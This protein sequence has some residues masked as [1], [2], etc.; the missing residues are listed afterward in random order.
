[1]TFD[2]ERNALLV[3]VDG[4]I[5]RYQFAGGTWGAPTSAAITDLQAFSLSANGT[6]I[7][8]LTKTGIT[9]VN[10][11]TLALGSTTAATG[12]SS[13]HT[14]KDLVITNENNGVVTTGAS[15]TT[16][17]PLFA[18]QS[19]KDT[20]ALSTS[21]AQLDNASVGISANGSTAIIV[22]GDPALTTAP[23]V[24]A[25]SASTEQLS[26]FLTSITLNQSTVPP[27]LNTG[28]TRVALNGLNVYDNAVL[29]G[30][31]PA[32]TAAL[33]FK[34]DGTRAYTYDTTAGAILT[35]DTSV[36]VTD[37]AAF[38]QVGT[39][40]AVPGAPGNGAR[41]TIS[42]DGSTLFLAGSTQAMVMPAPAF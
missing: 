16:Y 10:P 35:F 13:G 9:R 17:T 20:L 26:A 21:G 5:L 40:V 14:L 38:T 15:G 31:L 34:P 12:L 2:G 3:A 25:F 23:L 30:L 7:F 39:A 4:T 27:V 22:Q 32:T 1:L 11:V 36:A 41:M 42:L 28:A 18:F 8:A 19:R 6:E 33:A 37:A 24:Y 29:M